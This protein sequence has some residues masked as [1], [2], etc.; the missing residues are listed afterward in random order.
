MSGNMYVRPVLEYAS[1]VWSPYLIL[2]INALERVQRHF[3]KRIPCLANLSYPER[4]ATLDLEPLE[5]R[6]LKP[7]L[8]LYYKCLHELVARPSSECLTMSNFTSKT[9]TGGNR[10]L[11][12]LCSTRYY[13]NDF[14]NRCVSCWHFLPSR[15]SNA[16]YL[17]LIC[18]LLHFVPI[19]KS[20]LKDQRKWCI[21]CP[22][23]LGS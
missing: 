22:A 4:L 20:S 7:D 8:V 10:L 15:V 3:T 13:E 9:R 12:S 18:Q 2:H 11:R 19:F 1:N 6:R 5:I 16:V 14:F 23:I 17:T 21:I